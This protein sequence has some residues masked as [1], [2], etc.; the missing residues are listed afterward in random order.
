A[1]RI[2]PSKRTG[3]LWSYVA[4]ISGESTNRMGIEIKATIEHENSK[5]MSSIK[6]Q[7][8]QEDHL[9]SAAMEKFFQSNH[10]TSLDITRKGVYRFF[11]QAFVDI[12]GDKLL[13]EILYKD[14]SRYT[15]ALRHIPPNAKKNPDLV[16]KSYLDIVKIA[17]SKNLKPIK[18]STQFKHVKAMRS[19]FHWCMEAFEMKRDVTCCVKGSDYT[20]D[21]EQ[22]RTPFDGEDLK[23]IGTEEFVKSFNKAWKFFAIPLGYYTGARIN[24][25]AQLRV[26]DIHDVPIGV[27]ERGAPITTPCISLNACHR[28]KLKT[29]NAKRLV[30][31]HA[32][33]I[34]IG[35]LE[36]VKHVKELGFKHLFPD[37]QGR[38]SR[39]GSYISSWFN[40]THLKSWCGIDDVRKKFH[41]FRNHFIT[42]AELSVHVPYS[43][44]LALAGLGRGRDVA[45]VHYIK[46]ADIVACKKAMDAI[47]LPTFDY[48]TFDAAQ[49]EGYFADE[50]KY[51]SRDI[52][53]SPPE[54][55]KRGRP[56]KKNMP[57]Q[58]QTQALTPP[59]GQ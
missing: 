45:W 31:I 28:K 54:P 39:P 23:K 56:R 15:N 37:L 22:A 50:L 57:P 24:E 42:Y 1:R 35:F 48:P 19:F 25:I 58:E 5:L 20:R 49:F 13:S 36:L 30:P 26:E 46:S 21:E 33:L 12:V 29:R 53:T 8:I 44:L 38:R 6:E 41:S 47:Q 59:A 40:T 7:V 43:S 27:D 34:E 55:K 18:T 11:A 14:I 3:D 51:A 52:L 32:K 4:L 10:Y 17:Q 9:F 2:P 16:G